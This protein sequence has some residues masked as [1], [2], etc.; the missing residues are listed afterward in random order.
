MKLPNWKVVLAWLA[1]LTAWAPAQINGQ[2]NGG[3][4]GVM[5][6]SPRAPGSPS[7]PRMGWAQSRSPHR[8][9]QLLSVASRLVRTPTRPRS[10]STPAIATSTDT[11]V[12]GLTNSTAASSGNQAYSPALYLCGNGW[13]TTGGSSQPVCMQMDM[14]PS[15]GATPI[16][17]LNFLS[18]INGAGYSS[19]GSLSTAGQ[20][21]ANSF[22]INS[23]ITATNNSFGLAAG[24]TPAIWAGA[25]DAIQFTTTA[26]KPQ[27]PLVSSGTTFAFASGTGACATTSTLVEVFRQAI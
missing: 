2:I 8:A 12:F 11:L 13:G 22:A 15:Q 6:S 25:V 10:S 21:T 18:S 3:G 4:S 1:I 19:I 24:N 17:Y 16:G 27:V 20:M 5:P 23:A 26:V 9:R 7:H 14:Q